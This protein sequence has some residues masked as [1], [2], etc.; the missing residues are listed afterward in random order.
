MTNELPPTPI[1]DLERDALA[2]LANMRWRVP[3]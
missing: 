2:E 3:Q 1:S